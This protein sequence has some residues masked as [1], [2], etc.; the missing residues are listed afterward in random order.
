MGNLALPVNLAR[1]MQLLGC[2]RAQVA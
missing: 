1:I 2:G